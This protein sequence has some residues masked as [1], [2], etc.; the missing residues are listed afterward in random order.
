MKVSHYTK[1]LPLDFCRRSNRRGWCRGE[2][3]NSEGNSKAGGRA[4]AGTKG[5]ERR[6]V[7]SE[8]VAWAEEEDLENL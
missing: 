7:A 6:D 5:E 1:Q 8:E 2:E 4:Q 3:G